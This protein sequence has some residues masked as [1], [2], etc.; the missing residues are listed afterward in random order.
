MTRFSTANLN[1]KIHVQKVLGVRS[2]FTVSRSD[3]N[4]Q[5]YLTSLESAILEFQYYFPTDFH[6]SHMLSTCISTQKYTRKKFSV[7]CSFTI[8][9]INHNRMFY[10]TS[11]KYAIVALARTRTMHECKRENVRDPVK[12]AASGVHPLSTDSDKSPRRPNSPE[13]TD[14]LSHA[15]S[16]PRPFFSFSPDKCQSAKRQLLRATIARQQNEGSADSSE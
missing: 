15:G 4:E 2:S 11:L 16:S 12:A 14:A 5:Y 8:S 9:R 3:C 6:Y 7:R 13:R 10:S 1:T